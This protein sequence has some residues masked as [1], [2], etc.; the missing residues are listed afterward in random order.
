MIV[1]NRNKEIRTQVRGR[2]H[3]DLAEFYFHDIAGANL[4]QIGKTQ[5][6]GD[7]FGKRLYAEEQS[8]LFRVLNLRKPDGTPYGKDTIWQLLSQCGYQ[9]S[10]SKKDSKNHGKHYRIITQKG[11]NLEDV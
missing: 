6:P 4:Y 1:N 7:F 5:I 9:V 3:G 8:E 2:Y 10:E 11:T